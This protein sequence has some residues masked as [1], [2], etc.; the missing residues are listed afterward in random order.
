[1]GDK[2]GCSCGV[3]SVDVGYLMEGG[4]GGANCCAVW[5]FG[6]VDGVVGCG[7]DVVV[8]VIAIVGIDTNVAII[9]SVVI[10]SVVMGADASIATR[11]G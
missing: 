6:N 2:E 3:S 10:A 8:V 7:V 9:A 1:M 4:Y 11:C 5:W